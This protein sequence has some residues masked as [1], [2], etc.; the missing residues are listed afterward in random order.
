MPWVKLKTEKNQ[1]IKAGNKLHTIDA[2]SVP[3]PRSYSTNTSFTI[4]LS[5]AQEE[6]LLYKHPH[7]YTAPLSPTQRQRDQP[8]FTANS[9][10]TF[11]DFSPEYL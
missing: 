11:T 6:R 8:A 5:C 4:L 10:G 3:A 2:S 7:G 9:L 1:N